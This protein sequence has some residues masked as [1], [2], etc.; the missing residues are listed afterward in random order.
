MGRVGWIA[1]VAIG[2]SAPAAPP[3]APPAAPPVALAAGP[4]DAASLMADVTRLTAPELAGRG[5][6]QPGGRAAADLM[7][8]AL[9]EA[10]LEVVRQPIDGGADNVLG[11]LRGGPEAIVIS[12]HYDH[13]GVQDGVVYPGADD[14]AS[15]AAVLLGLA[16][17]AAAR[18]RR[19]T[20]IFAAFGAEEAG[21]KGAGA[22][23]RAPLWPLERTLAIV[24]FD[25]V[26]RRF[27]DWGGGAEH[28]CAVVGLEASAELAAAARESADEAGLRLVP[29][30]ARVVELFGMDDRTDEWWFRRQQIPAIHFSTSLHD[31][32]HRPSDRLEAIEPDQLE[33]IARTADGLIEFLASRWRP[34]A[35]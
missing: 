9:S 16:R 13:L 8:A 30:P 35:R 1:A 33:R 17:A 4:L 22:Y 14:N 20:L 24:N 29:V 6:F 3:P 32:Y 25:M 7:A 31:D 2:C 27:F 5:S 18:P 10:G 12:A 15:G 23:V 21:L 34:D 26:G 28:T 11:V 19:N